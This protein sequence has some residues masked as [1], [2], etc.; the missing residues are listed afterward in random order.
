M[1]CIP[2]FCPPNNFP[3][4]CLVWSCGRERAVPEFLRVLVTLW[5]RGFV[6]VVFSLGSPIAPA[7]IASW[8]A[9]H[10]GVA[11]RHVGLTAASCPVPS[12]YQKKSNLSIFLG[13]PPPCCVSR[14][15]AA[16]LNSYHLHSGLHLWMINGAGVGSAPLMLYPKWVN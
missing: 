3:N 6:R 4:S 12:F 2:P 9:P 5:W 13:T 11:Y 16:C 14:G 8:K 1:F 15:T 10:A 7:M